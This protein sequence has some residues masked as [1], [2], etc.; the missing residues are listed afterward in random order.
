MSEINQNQE[1]GLRVEDRDIEFQAGDIVTCF[2]KRW[3]YDSVAKIYQSFRIE[4]SVCTWDPGFWFSRIPSFKGIHAFCIVKH[5]RGLRS[6]PHKTF[7]FVWIIPVIL[8]CKLFAPNE[9]AKC[10]CLQRGAAQRAALLLPWP[11]IWRQTRLQLAGTIWMINNVNPQLTL[12]QDRQGSN[13]GE[14]A[15]TGGARRCATGA[16]AAYRQRRGDGR[17]GKQSSTLVP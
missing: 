15:T 14:G 17:R 7:L 8:M 4:P 6:N 10:C 12:C 3:I 11:P 9:M 16:G 5:I 13:I 1:C 2:S